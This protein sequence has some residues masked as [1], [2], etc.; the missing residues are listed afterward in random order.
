VF[1]QNQKWTKKMSKIG[2]GK[3][4]FAKNRFCDHNEK[5]ASA[6][7]FKKK[8][9]VSIIFLIFCEKNL[10]IFYYIIYGYNGR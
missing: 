10:G 6:G 7:V 2:K 1:S 3:K 4:T 8:Y 9:F 5:L